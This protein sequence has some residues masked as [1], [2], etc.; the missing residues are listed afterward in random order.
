MPAP[1][2]A[3]LPN[4]W[5]IA[6]SGESMS[7]TGDEQAITL[8]DNYGRVLDVVRTNWRLSS[9]NYFV[10]NN[11]RSPSHWSEW[12]GA[13]NRQNGG[14]GSYGRDAAAT[15]TNTGR[16]GRTRSRARWVPTTVRRSVRR[17]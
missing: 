8:Y 13:V 4:Y 15:D 6:A 16:T 7:M 11:P 17:W 5:N 3:S 1:V 12:G 14:E 2:S 9:T 10:N